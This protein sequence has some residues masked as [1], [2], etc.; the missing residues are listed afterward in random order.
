MREPA[1]RLAFV[2]LTIAAPAR[3]RRRSA[4]YV[5]RDLVREQEAA[6]VR[7]ESVLVAELVTAAPAPATSRS[8]VR[9]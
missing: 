9:S 7:E 5:L 2:V 4:S 8:T 6:H 1:H 3:R